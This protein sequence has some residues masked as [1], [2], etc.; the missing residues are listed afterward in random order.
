MITPLLGSD[1]N[2][3]VSGTNYGNFFGGGGGGTWFT[4][5]N[6]YKVVMAVAGTL[7]NFYVKFTNAPGV[8]TS[9][10]ITVRKNGSDTACAVT[11]AD[12]ATT[13]SDTSNSV[14]FSVGDTLSLKIADS[15]SPGNPGDMTYMASYTSTTANESPWFTCASGLPSDDSTKYTGAIAG[16]SLSTNTEAETMVMPTDGVI[17]K[18][19][20]QTASAP[21][22]TETTV[23]TLV[24]NGS[25]TALTATVANA[26]TTA[27]DTT[28]TVSV[29]A[30][31]KV[32]L[33]VVDSSGSA[34]GN[35]AIGMRWVPTIT[36]EAVVGT[37]SATNPSNAALRYVN[38]GGALSAFPTTEGDVQQYYPAGTLKKLRLDF[39]T[40]PGAGKS[41]AVMTR[42]GA[43]NTALTA[44]VADA[45]TT[46]SDTSNT[47]SVALLDLVNFTTTPS[48]TPAA[49]NGFRVSMVFVEPSVGPAGVKTLNG[50][51]LASVKTVNGIATAS[52][53]S[54]NGI[55]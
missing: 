32:Y 35:C 51:S 49:P 52:V 10:T 44:T 43:A 31:D 25:D 38:A 23:V 6:N 39:T 16:V 11:I 7:A 36:N 55:A 24:K 19:Y 47:V 5:E 34:S 37:A 53:K 27:N 30:G 14:A 48:G 42:N 29:S 2:S 15:G 21:G 40:A 50:V 54:I 18:L 17:D 33:K 4:N 22:A 26:A 13:G 12:A 41:R 9:K 8:G 45:N 46:A 1:A 28:N 3:T 20:L